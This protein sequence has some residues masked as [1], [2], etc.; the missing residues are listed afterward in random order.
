M[1]SF[2][3]TILILHF[4][5]LALGMSV[6]AANLVMLQVMH[7]AQPGERAVLARFP[8][9]MSRVGQIGLALLWFT[10]LGMVYTRWNGIGGMPWFFHVKLA[11]VL[12][13][14]GVVFY[15]AHLERRLRAGDR[16]AQARIQVVGKVAALCALTAVVFA[17]LTFD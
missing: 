7:R 10:G 13:L 12:I 16:A 1:R 4:I 9:A 5:G 15:I 14:T 3:Q 8:P 17:V 2:S 11:A 6:S